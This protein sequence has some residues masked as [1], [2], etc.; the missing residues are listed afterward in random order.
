MEPRPGLKSGCGVSALVPD[1]SHIR[2]AAK[3]AI[4]KDDVTDG[5]RHA[6]E[7]PDEA[8][9]QRVRAGKSAVQR[10]VAVRT[11][12][13]RQQCGVKA[14]ARPDQHEEKEQAGAEKG[15]DCVA[16]AIQEPD[17]EERCNDARWYHKSDRISVV[18]LEA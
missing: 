8:Y 11:R 10:D 9:L 16:I 5:Q 15:L 12:C 1:G 17:A 13:C 18:V 14:P 3:S 7:P 4:D 2:F 6:E